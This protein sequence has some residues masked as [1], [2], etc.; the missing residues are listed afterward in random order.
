MCWPAIR[1][2]EQRCWEEWVRVVLGGEWRID[3]A[4]AYGYRD[5]RAITPM[6]KRLEQSAQADAGLESR[7]KILRAD[8]DSLP[9]W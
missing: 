9:Q 3:V 1:E 4:Q 6:L 5:G 8:F 2:P 7:M